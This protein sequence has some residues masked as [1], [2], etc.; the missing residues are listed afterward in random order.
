MF[1]GAVNRG[2]LGWAGSQS[3]EAVVL[4]E[5]MI[6]GREDT[7]VWQRVNNQ[8]FRFQTRA[9]DVLGQCFQMLTDRHRRHIERREVEC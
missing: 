7:G 3:Y 1:Y 2:W 8:W 6:N 4:E 5:V 9:T